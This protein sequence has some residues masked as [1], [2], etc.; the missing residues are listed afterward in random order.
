MSQ[1]C[2]LIF[3]SKS[4]ADL[5]FLITQ[6]ARIIFISMDI[7]SIQCHL[8]KRA[9][10]IWGTTRS[11]SSW[12]TVSSTTGL[13]FHSKAWL[14]A[15]HRIFLFLMCVVFFFF[16]CV[17]ALFFFI[18]YIFILLK[19]DS[20]LTQ[21]ILNRVYLSSTLPSSSPH[22]FPSRSTSFCLSL[23]NIILLRDN[24]KT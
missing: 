17:S 21:N 22:L 9:T 23:E 4:H 10:F 7:Q 16:I 6:E 11:P 20:L 15:E 24:N 8:L 18:F 14:G 1:T 12:L 2:S 3:S 19:I 5:P 13:P